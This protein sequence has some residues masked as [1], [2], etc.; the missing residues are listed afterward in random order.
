MFIFFLF[1]AHFLRERRD[2]T[3]AMEADRISCAVVIYAMGEI[4]MDDQTSEEHGDPALGD[5]SR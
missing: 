5:S 1:Y 4:L 3:I 2:N